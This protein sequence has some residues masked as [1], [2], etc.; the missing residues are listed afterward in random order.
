MKAELVAM[1]RAETAAAVAGLQLGALANFSEAISERLQTWGVPDAGG[2]RY[3]RNEQD[4]IAGDQLRSAHGKGVRAMLHAAFTI[5]L[6]Q[7]CFDRELPHPGFVVL[8]SPLVTYRPP[9]PG[10]QDD[11]DGVMDTSVAA[12]FYADIQATFD[13]QILIMENMDPPDGLET[14]SMDVP[15]TKSLTNG[16]YGFFPYLDPANQAPASDG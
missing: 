16:R 11:P 12:R 4:L 2:V 1:G 3:D 6:A 14:D 15:F 9:E 7:Y 8:D 5:G 13:G 10:E